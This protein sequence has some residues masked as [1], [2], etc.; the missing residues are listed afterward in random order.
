MKTA[1]II[2]DWGAYATRSSDDDD[3]LTGYSV[4]N[5]H[6]YGRRRYVLR[7]SI[8]VG[9]LMYAFDNANA[10]QAVTVRVAKKLDTRLTTKTCERREVTRTRGRFDAGLQQRT[11][12]I[13]Y[14]PAAMGR[15]CRCEAAR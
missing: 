2:I 7:F 8:V 4:S 11:K 3:G 9:W 1:E 5:Y 12:S 6:H 10:C 15:C 13:A 14:R